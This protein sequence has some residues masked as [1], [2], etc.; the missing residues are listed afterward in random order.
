MKLK[1]L[2]VIFAVTG[3]L[4]LYF[5][6]TLTQ[7]AIIILENISEY[8]GKQVTATGIVAEYYT[9]QYGSQLI[10]IQDD[11][12]S[13]IVFLEEAVNVEYG[14][15]LQATGKVQ[16]YKEEWEIIVENIK[17]VKILEKW[18]N[19]S[20]PVWQLAQNPTKYLGLNVNVSG[21]VDAVFDTYLHLKDNENNNTLLVFYNT[22]P[23]LY[24]GRQVFASGNFLFDEQNLRYYLVINEEEHGIFLKTEE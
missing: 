22:N 1:H 6:S 15:K 9:T 12:G 20:F 16:K 11:N 24:R 7:P 8:D 18:K 3:T 2:A 10:T 13:A 19:A 4:L 5:A 17:D 21:R 23:F 14:D